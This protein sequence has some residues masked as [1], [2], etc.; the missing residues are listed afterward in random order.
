[1]NRFFTLS[2]GSLVCAGFCLSAASA[3]ESSPKEKRVNHEG[4]VLPRMPKIEKPVMFNTPEAD[5]ILS[6][7][8]IFPKNNP[9]NEDISKLPVHLNSVNLIKGMKHR[10]P[11]KLGYNLDMCFVLVPPGQPKVK[12]KL[13][14]YPGE[15]DKGPYPVPGNAPIEGWPGLLRMYPL[16]KGKGVK[17]AEIQRQGGG[18]RHLIVV[19]PVNMTLYEFFTARKTD[20]GWQ[21]GAAAIFDLKSNKLR[22]EG[23]TSSDAAGLP[24]F[25][26]VVRYDEC[27]R[28]MVEHALRVT[29]RKSR[30]AY[31]YPARHYASRSKN[32]NHPAMGDRLRLKASVDISGFS[33]HAK[34]I[35]KA[36]KKYGMI[37]ADNGV[38]WLVSIAPDPRL[39]GLDDLYKLR[40]RDFEFVVTTGEREGPRAPKDQNENR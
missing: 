7:M 33:K 6:A 5:A 13:V 11:L 9:W 36:L 2:L 3:G 35:A 40:P 28:G 8:Q 17:L 19:D 30:R 16:R 37:V 34:A 14:S 1:M 31:V 32:K 18:D 15:S 39:K 10:N 27:E 4:R 22:P 29:V 21:A 24:I 25:P 26:A 20:A 23:W 38:D 12:V